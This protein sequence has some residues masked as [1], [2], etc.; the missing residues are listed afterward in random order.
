MYQVVPEAMATA[1]FYTGIKGMQP[2]TNSDV[3]K[4]L[5][6]V[7]CRG[8]H[9]PTA[10]NIVT[11]YQKHL[12]IVKKTNICFNCLGHHEV[13]QC[14]SKFC[15]KKCKHKHHTSLCKPNHEEPKPR[16]ED[17]DDQGNKDSHPEQPK[18]TS[19]A[20]LTPVSYHTN[21][22]RTATEVR[23]VCLLQT[24]IAP[25]SV[26][27]VRVHANILFDEGAQRSFITEDLAAKLNLQP[28]SSENIA[29]ASFGAESLSNQQLPVAQ[30][31]VETQSGDLIP[32]SVLI[33]PM[34]AAPLQNTL[35]TCIAS[36]PY[37]KHLTL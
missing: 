4:K 8:S 16:D 1:S 18:N 22:N 36:Y 17:K 20:T 31:N 35:R 33:V 15:C 27:V 6:C 34:I 25:I 26:E 14:G 28:V 21:Q 29:V 12:E 23:P 2:T 32:I 5:A 13:S 37:L 3:K 10:C 24:A 11:D 30:I 9:S 19:H 7:Y